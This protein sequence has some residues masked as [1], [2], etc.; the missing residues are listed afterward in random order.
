MPG[1]HLD[2][3]LAVQSC[4][5]Y[6]QH[7]GTQPGGPRLAEGREKVELVTAGRGWVQHGGGLAEVTA[8]SLIWHVPGERMIQ[9]SDD[10]APYS[11]LSITWVVS[12]PNRQCPRLT[13]WDDP[14]AALACTRQLSAA[15]GDERIDRR[16]L[17]MC[18]YAQLL[19]R[20][21]LHAAT[22]A[23]SDLPRPLAEVLT[24][25]QADPARDWAIGD[26][27]SL[28]GWGA[29]RLHAAFRDHLRTTPHQHLLEL[30]LRRAREMLALHDDG[31]DAIA[32][33]CGMAGAAVLCRRFRRATGVT[34]GAYRRRLR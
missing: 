18:S 12:A 3:V 8:G 17:A 2:H 6:H 20:A 14:D 7:A 4:G 34:P 21:H 29:S 10:A 16:T 27:C 25:L 31:L 22:A 9:R 33:A 26:M 30:R 32:R 5:H 24:A 11:C 19:W 15:A 23:G 13:R 1:P 28:A